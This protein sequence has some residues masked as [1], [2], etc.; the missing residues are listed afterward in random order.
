M[1]SISGPRVKEFNLPPEFKEAFDFDSAKVVNGYLTLRHKSGAAI[2]CEFDGK[3]LPT[4]K[5]KLENA[6]AANEDNVKFDSNF[7]SRKFVIR[8][9]ELL[10]QDAEQEFERIE[11]SRRKEQNDKQKILDG[12]SKDKG[13]FRYFV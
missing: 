12:I 10:L 13:C 8:F 7:D 3:K 4:F 1:S 6:I 2:R 11:L 5:K 9:I